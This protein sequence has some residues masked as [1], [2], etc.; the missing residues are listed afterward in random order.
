MLLLPTAV[1]TGC[2]GL[3]GAACFHQAI[4]H[5]H[6]TDAASTEYF[7]PVSCPLFIDILLRLQ[8]NSVERDEEVEKEDEGRERQEETNGSVLNLSRAQSDIHEDSIR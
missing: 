8:K 2:S 3:C 4:L 5:L 6:R 7:R 1:R